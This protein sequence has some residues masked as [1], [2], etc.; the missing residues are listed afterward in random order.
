MTEHLMQL[1]TTVAPA[2]TF[3]VDEVSYQLLGMDHLSPNSEANVMANFTRYGAMAERLEQI[4]DETKATALALKMRGVRL[5]VLEKMTTCP[6]D[7]LEKIPMSGQ[8]QMMNALR[9]E[10]DQTAGNDTEDDDNEDGT[11]D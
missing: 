4:N 9:K 8:I 6:M 1:S 10:L 7:V 2:K 5:S 3:T 11:N